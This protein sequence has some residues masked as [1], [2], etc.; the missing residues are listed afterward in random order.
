MRVPSLL[1][2]KAALLPFPIE[3]GSPLRLVYLG[4]VHLSLYIPESVGA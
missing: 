4:V 2:L 1:P 3:N